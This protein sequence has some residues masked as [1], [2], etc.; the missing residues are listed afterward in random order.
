MLEDVLSKKFGYTGVESK[1]TR[2]NDDL[3]EFTATGR[4]PVVPKT[5]KATSSDTSVL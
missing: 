5:R 2:V 4:E 1:P 3:W